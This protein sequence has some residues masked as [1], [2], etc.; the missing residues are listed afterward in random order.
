LDKPKVSII[1]PNKD[2]LKLLANCVDSVIKKSTYD[3]YEI[4]I[5]ENNSTSEE[6]FDYYKLIEQVECVKVLKYDK[7]FNYSAVNN[8]AVKESTGEYIVFLNND[9][10]IIT[11]GWIEELLMYAQRS[12]IGAVGAKLYY[13]NNTVQHN[14]VIIGAGADKIA[15]HS[16]AGESR[17]DVGYM[18]RL[19]YAQNVS[20]VTAACMMVSRKLFDEL[21]GFD[22]KL[23]VA[24]NDVDLCLRIREKNYLIVCNSFIEAY[25]YE[26]IS[27]GYEEKRGN[28]DRFRRE[29]DYMK[30]KWDDVLKNEDPFYNPNVSKYKPWKFG[31]KAQD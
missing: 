12:D 11:P 22:E 31:I 24:Y 7:P 4:L 30:T 29:V 15:I 28:Q 6:I 25:H 23:A 14:G 17:Y 1:I 3:N 8:Y 10:E 26:S 16:H 21:G 19:F 27:R 5:V 9:I 2:N 13:G 20:A 18:G